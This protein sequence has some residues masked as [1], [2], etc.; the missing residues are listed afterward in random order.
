VTT[1]KPID[2]G[3]FLAAT[4]KRI[5]PKGVTPERFA[6]RYNVSRPRK[7][8]A[9][10]TAYMKQPGVREAWERSAGSRPS[11]TRRLAQRAAAIQ[12][13]VKRDAKGLRP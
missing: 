1:T 4:L 6:P 11:K 7:T 12:L 5:T 2:L 10:L 13:A 8:M 3:K 9:A